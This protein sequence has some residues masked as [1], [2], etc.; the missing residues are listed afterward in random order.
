MITVCDQ[1][2]DYGFTGL[3]IF[4][5][6]KEMLKLSTFILSCRVLGRGVEYA[7]LTEIA[8]YCKKAEIKYLSLHYISTPKNVPIKRF[9]DEIGLT[10]SS[11]LISDQFSLE[12]LGKFSKYNTVVNT[13]YH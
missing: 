8:E 2:G 5:V 6:T 9:L 3:V 1:F 13:L 12:K 11:E 10:N 7:V 4:N